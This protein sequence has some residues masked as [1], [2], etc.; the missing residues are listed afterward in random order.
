M[1][2]LR[3]SC[4][5]NT[6]YEKAY[7]TKEKHL[8]RLWIKINIFLSSYPILHSHVRVFCHCFDL[9]H[10]DMCKN[11]FSPVS[12]LPRNDFKCI[13]CSTLPI[14]LSLLQF[15]SQLMGTPSSC[16]GI[17]NSF[18]SQV[19]FPYDKKSHSLC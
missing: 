18:L 17:S 6:H 19:L 12:Y 16:L 1:S 13:S 5:K 7:S 8:N 15:S 2:T 9:K 11:K 3:V 4:R 10:H 14:L